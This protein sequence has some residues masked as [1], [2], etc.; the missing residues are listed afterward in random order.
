MNI[1]DILEDDEP[2]YKICPRCNLTK[3]CECDA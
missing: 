2:K 1:L 3:P